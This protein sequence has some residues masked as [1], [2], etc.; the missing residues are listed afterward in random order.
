MNDWFNG[1]IEFSIVFMC[2]T[3]LLYLPHTVQIHVWQVDNWSFQSLTRLYVFHT[4]SLCAHTHIRAGSHTHAMRPYTHARTL[5]HTHTHTHTNAHLH[6]ST[7]TIAH[8]H[9]RLNRCTH[10]HTHTHTLTQ[11]E[12]KH[13][14]LYIE[15]SLRAHLVVAGHKTTQ[16]H[17]NS[18]PFTRF[19]PTAARQLHH[20]ISHQLCVMSKCMCKD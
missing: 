19:A 10:T 12:Q 2:S 4:S 20:Q 5:S 6:T 16:R 1:M 9:I 15:R 8:L 14:H 3:F 13:W 17:L 18:V 11:A 7:L